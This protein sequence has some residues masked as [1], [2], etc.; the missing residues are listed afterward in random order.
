MARKKSAKA[1]ATTETSKLDTHPYFVNPAQVGGIE[2][3]QIDDGAGRGVRALCV[4]T[5]GGLRYRV[6][7]DRGLDIDHAFHNQHSLA[8]LTH[9]GVTSPSR[10]YDH[11]IDWLASFPGGLLTTCGPFNIGPP[12]EDQGEQLPLHGHHSNT[13]ATIESIVQ[14]DPRGGRNEMSITGVV[15]YGRLFARN[16]ELR[17]TI[18]SRLGE[19]AIDF[20]DEFSNLGNGP[21]PHAWLLHINLG[22][23]LVQAG[24][25][26]CYDSPKV[27]PAPSDESQDWFKVGKPYKTAPP[28]LER[29]RGFTEAVAYLRPRAGR[30]G[31]ATVGVVN[32]T[33]GLGLAIRYN[34]REFPRCINW[35][36]WG[37]G[38]YVTA[39]EPVNGTVQGRAKDREQGLLD[40][41]PAGG[42]KTY[43]YRIEAVSDRA[44]LDELRSLNKSI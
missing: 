22:Y 42:R 14:P 37:P 24:T 43:R 39:L 19:N 40:E 34:T 1:A 11:G 29:H 38:E 36:H 20:V 10:A 3:Y 17:R 18:T 2:S 35:Q 4:N 41:I 30:D 23:P 16:V 15:R 28:P 7:V 13:P 6:L 27:E 5:G 12:G 21:V 25:E 26:F 32:R 44:A 9:G 31:Q 33:L 8:F